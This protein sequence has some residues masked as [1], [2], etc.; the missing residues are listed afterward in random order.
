VLNHYRLIATDVDDTLFGAECVVSP[1]TRAAIAAALQRGV[2][3]TLVTGRSFPTVHAIARDLSLTAPVVIY[4][5]AVCRLEDGQMLF[6]QPIPV[7]LARALI[8]ELHARGVSPVLFAG[9]ALYSDA[10]IPPQIAPRSGVQGMTQHILRDGIEHLEIAPEKIVVIL[11]TE[12]VA[13]L[14]AALAELGGHQIRIIHTYPMLLEVVHSSCM[15]SRSLEWLARHLG[16]LR[17]QVMAVSDGDGDADMLAWA[18]LGVAMGNAPP[19]ARA[20]SDYVTD[21]VENDGL[22]KAIEHFVL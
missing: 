13:D 21:S 22:A 19:T 16:I 17:K 3:V 2:I 8:A 12:V 10:P 9:T 5:G 7:P 4:N 15:K 11:P 18:G 1:R 14:Q 20:A 6:H